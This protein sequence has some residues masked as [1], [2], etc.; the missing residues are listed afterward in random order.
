M[1][2][3]QALGGLTGRVPGPLYRFVRGLVPIA[4]VDLLPYRQTQAGTEIGLIL[5]HDYRSTEVW[6]FIGGGIHRG[7]SV[8]A[9]ADRHLHETLGADVSQAGGGLDLPV[10]VGEYLPVRFSDEPHDPRKHA[11]ALTYLVELDGIPRPQGEALAFEWFAADAVPTERMGFGQD[12]VY[13]SLRAQPSVAE[14]LS[15]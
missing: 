5:R 7:E 15:G 4:C 1:N 6:C 3:R 9:A 10:A 11:I 12:R 14:A 13:A 2:A 8:A